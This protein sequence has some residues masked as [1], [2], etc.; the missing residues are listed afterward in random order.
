MYRMKEIGSI[1][2]L[3]PQNSLLEYRS[4]DAKAMITLFWFLPPLIRHQNL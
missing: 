3:F 2:Q 1:A 4:A